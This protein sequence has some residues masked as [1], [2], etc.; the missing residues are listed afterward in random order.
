MSLGL[1]LPM[2]L[3]ALAALVVP[4]LIHLVRRPEQKPYDFPALRWLNESERPR[5]R[6]RLDEITLLI[7]RLLLLALL[8]LLLAVP[9][10]HGEWRGPRHWI[11]ASTSVDTDA[12]RKLIPDPQ[13]EWRWLA[14]G[15][16]AMDAQRPAGGQP[17]ASLLREFE[18]GLAASDSLTVL[19]PEELDGLDAQRITLGRSVEWVVV[20]AA[21]S[22]EAGV[23]TAASQSVALRY[24]EAEESSL[25][26]LRAA[27]DA[28][29]AAEPAR[30]MVD[31]APVSVPV[32]ASSRILVWLGA[33][34]P[35]E[36][37]QWIE[38]GGRAVLIDPS[39][40]VGSVALRDDDG[41]ALALEQAVGDGRVIRFLRPLTPESL[42]M[43]LD[44]GFP[45]RLKALLEGAP[46]A[47]TRALAAEVAPRFGERAPRTP[48]TP[49]GGVLCLLIAVVFLLERVVATRRQ[50]TP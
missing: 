21:S 31:S 44:A 50:S 6:L 2:G 13:A 26:Y 24:A 15:F 20:P 48:M 23:D 32:E 35:A 39:A 34:L 10:L 49:L 30:W 9:V 29:Q 37:Q 8:A 5:R 25:R 46:T 38:A 41:N 22:S 14:D 3:A 43:L 36:V 47:P 11:L 19:V 45:K 28:L 27:L 17:V 4:L 7:L 18:S 33:D 12:A 1:L 16:P 42:P 40:T